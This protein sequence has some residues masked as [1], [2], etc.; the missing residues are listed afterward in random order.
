M[1]NTQYIP[2]DIQQNVDAFQQNVQKTFAPVVDA[3][4]SVGAR[5]EVPAAARDFMKRSAEMAGERAADIH[6][7]TVRATD[8]VENAASKTVSGFAR[9]SRDMQ[10]AAYDDAKAYL[11]SVTKI[12]EAKSLSEAM[13]IQMD[14]VR[15]RTE[16]NM[17]R[18]KSMFDYVSGSLADAGKRAQETVSKVA[19]FNKAA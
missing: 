4:K 16:A 15:E 1:S 12:A 17:G 10:V 5:M 14:F 9:L 18:A 7:G 13:Q 11:A 19:N 8:A 2:H 6:A 3:M